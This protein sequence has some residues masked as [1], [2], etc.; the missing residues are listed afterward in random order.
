[1]GDQSIYVFAAVD[2]P[3][4]VD[5]VIAVLAKA[6]LVEAPRSIEHGSECLPGPAAQK[7]LGDGF[8]YLG[9][10]R[11]A[12]PGFIPEDPAID[13]RCPHCDEDVSEAFYDC[14]ETLVDD[15]TVDWATAAFSCPYCDW[16]GRLVDVR[17]A[18]GVGAFAR[19][20]F[21]FF[22]SVS[23]SE[24]QFTG[25]SRMIQEAIPDARIV[26]YDFT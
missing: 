15:E 20:E 14:V 5:G 8:E 3:G 24:E 26:L 4:F 10:R 23:A 19:R 13:A 11:T 18:A 12:L 6:Q 17:D 16:R 25:L 21:L 7:W 22:N 1:M 2:R 9:V